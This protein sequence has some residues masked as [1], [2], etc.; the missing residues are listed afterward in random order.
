M[1]RIIP[2]IEKT[3]AH[4]V[5][6]TFD[7]YRSCYVV[8]DHKT[9]LIDC[10]YPMDQPSLLAGLNELGLDPGDIDYL[11]LTHIHMDHAGA[12]GALTQLNP[13]LVVCVHTRGGRHLVDPARLLQG[14]AQA[15][16]D[17]FDEIGTMLPVPDG[18]IRVIDSGDT[19]ELGAIS[20]NVYATPGHAGH[21]V[22]FHDASVGTLFSGDALGSKIAERPGYILTP[23]GGYDKRASI[24]D[25][26]LI[27][28]LKPERINFAHC[29]T[30]RLDPRKRF[31]EGLKEMHAQWNRCV[32]EIL[33]E[34]PKI[35]NQALWDLFLERQPDLLRY[36]D[37]HFSFQMSV[38]GIRGYLE[39]RGRR[40]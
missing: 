16:G 1:T 4:T 6:L 22:I 40:A 20:L 31:L 38:R 2:R 12:A 25:I 26:D 13:E 17:H 15:Y 7:G 5:S 9:A 8:R 33:D 10:G 27:Q 29:G 3:D 24:R 30:Y 34:N 21:H 19:I 35:E 18:N 32:S 11:A 23:P 36:P 14:A 39:H 37:Q 28:S